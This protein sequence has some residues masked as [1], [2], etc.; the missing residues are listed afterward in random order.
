MKI[1]KESWVIAAIGIADL[2]T[3]IIFIQHH[4][5]QEANPVFRHYWNMGLQAF[6]AA[7]AICV[8]GPLFILEWARRR[9]PRFVSWALRTAIVCYL[10]LYGI[11]VAKLNAPAA[12]AADVSGTEVVADQSTEFAADGAKLADC[13]NL[14]V[15][16]Y[17]IRRSLF[18]KYRLHRSFRHNHHNHAPIGVGALGNPDAK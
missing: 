10:C 4:G 6:I 5:A 13:A 2:V 7:K 1:A 8:A 12:R 18:L 17:P 3:T 15:R 9:N 16:Y 14:P 11:G